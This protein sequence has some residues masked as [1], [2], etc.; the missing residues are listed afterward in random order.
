[1]SIEHRVSS[2]EV[3]LICMSEFPSVMKSKF[4]SPGWAS[5]EPLAGPISKLQTKG[6]ILCSWKFS[7][8]DSIFTVAFVEPSKYK[9]LKV[10]N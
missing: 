3:S 9:V 5:E 1:M 4:S 8:E 6:Q 10:K 2:L 7:I